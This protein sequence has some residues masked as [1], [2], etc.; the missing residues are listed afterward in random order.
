MAAITIS[1]Q[2][3]SMGRQVAEQVAVSLGYRLLWRELINQAARRAQVPEVAL[4]TI[5]ELDLLGLRPSVKDVRAYHAAVR[6]LMFEMADLGSVVIVGRAGQAIL[7]GVQG[8]LHV[9]IFA[10]FDLRV[11][12]I[13]EQHNQSAEAAH[14]QVQ[15]SDQSRKRYLRHYYHAGWDDPDLYDVMINTANLGVPAAAGVVYAALYQKL[16]NQA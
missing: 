4:A 6:D 3:G 12:R 2:M 13:A 8:V 14:A 5:D 9:R 15:A 1:R 7:R 11:T 16:Q 10:P